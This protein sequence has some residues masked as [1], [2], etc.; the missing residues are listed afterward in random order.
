MLKI[1]VI[2]SGNGSNLQALINACAAPNFPARIMMVIANRPEAYGLT[3]AAKAGLPHFLI[4]H[5]GYD[6]RLNFEAALN[7]TLNQEQIDLICLAGF[8][9]VLSAEF[10][11]KWHDRVINIHPS[12]LPAYE[13][14]HTHKRALRDNCAYH[15]ATVHYVRPAV[16]N[17]PLIL[18][19]K[20]PVLPQD[21]VETLAKRVLAKEHSLYPLCIKLIADGR[22]KTAGDRVR[23]DGIIGPRQLDE[24]TAISF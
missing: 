8:M 12:L 19:A 13:G 2:I 11:Q 9:R 5:N 22:V 16:D 4:D 7:E 17:G 6:N 15:G 21:T 23:I 20:V 1:A 3:R 10:T 14:L 18:Q 24:F